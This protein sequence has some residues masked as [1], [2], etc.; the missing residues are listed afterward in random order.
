M[1]SGWVQC[2]VVALSLVLLPS[3]GSSGKSGFV[4]LASQ[5]STPG[6]VSAYSVNLGNGLLHSNNGALVQ[7]GKSTAAG[8]QPTVLL[9]DPTNTFAYTAN[10]GSNDISLFTIGKDG[11]LSAAASTTALTNAAHPSGLAMDPGA[12]FL[13]VANQGQPASSANPV[14]IPGNLSVFA[15]GSS[16]A[17]SEVAGSPFTIQETA[18]P[19][20]FNPV[21]PLPVAVAVSHQGNFVYV[22]DQA[23]NA[24]VSFSF[25]STSGA[26]TPIAQGCPQCFGV[27]VGTAP[28]AVLSPPAGD[29]LYVANSSSNDIFEFAVDPDGT[30]SPITAKTTTIATGVGPIAMVTDPSAKYLYALANQGSQV[31]GYTLNQVTGELTAITAAG[32]TVSTGANPVAFSLISD[33]S[34]DGNFWLFVSNNGASSVSTYSLEGTTG[35]LTALPQ[36]TSPLAPYGIGTR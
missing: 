11:S 4:Y 19:L 18:P 17:L 9:F 1:K 26:L 22:A 5:G 6:M 21:S 2:V 23:N 31:L 25:D 33:G 14:A 28:S 34:R 12:H 8:T 30:L 27:V 35:K 3:C 7:T 36:L 10:F 29:F 15:I 16:G 24:L 13:F 20:P 32:G